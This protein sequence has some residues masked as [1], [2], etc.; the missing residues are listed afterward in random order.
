MPEETGEKELLNTKSVVSQSAEENSPDDDWRIIYDDSRIQDFFDALFKD[1][2]YKPSDIIRKA[3]MSR[4]VGY[5]IIDGKRVG[6]RDHYL[7]I[8]IAMKLDL[9]TTQ[10]LL[11]VVERGTLNPNIKRDAAI[12]QAI[13]Q[14]YDNDKLFDF[15]LSL[16]LEPLYTG[17]D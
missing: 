12:I 11:T 8:A 1:R 7:S 6:R 15:L 10:R 16:D 9:L 2:G 14:G 4:V 13:E 17:C 3:E 5:Q